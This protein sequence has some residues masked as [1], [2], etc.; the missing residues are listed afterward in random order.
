MGSEKILL[1]PH[2]SRSKS[3]DSTETRHQLITP[4]MIPQVRAV[5]A[6]IFSRHDPSKPSLQGQELVQECR[7]GFG[8]DA[9]S[10]EEWAWGRVGD[11]Y[12]ARCADC[13]F[14]SILMSEG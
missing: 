14:A 6:Q 1:Q 9:V 8:P 12:A 4:A 3:F 13:R 11:C 10:Q 7:L 2:R 5:L